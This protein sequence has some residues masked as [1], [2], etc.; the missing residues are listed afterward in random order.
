MGDDMGAVFPGRSY[1]VGWDE[2]GYEDSIDCN[3]ALGLI[4]LLGLIEL[5]RDMIE[6]MT[7]EDAPAEGERRGLRTR[8]SLG[9][10]ASGLFPTF[11]SDSSPGFLQTLPVVLVP[12]LHSLVDAND[13]YVDPSCLERSLCEANHQL[14]EMSSSNGFVDQ[15]A[16]GF[17][18]SLLTKV[19]AKSFTSFDS[20]RYRS[21]V[22]AAEA[23]RGGASCQLAYPKCELLK[24]RHRPLASANFTEYLRRRMDSAI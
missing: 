14:T 2:G 22:N 13:G 4:G 15:A 12:L 7:K 10:F 23:G 19:A 5:L 3:A 1:E 20:K 17:V 21:A 18:A 6:D 24:D 9:S 11:F 16:S 8:R